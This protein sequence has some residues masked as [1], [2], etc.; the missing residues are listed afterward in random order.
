MLS[1]PQK[2][3]PNFFIA[4]ALPPIAIPNSKPMANIDEDFILLS[5]VKD[6]H[7]FSR[8]PAPTGYVPVETVGCGWSLCLF[9][10]SAFSVPDGRTPTTGVFCSVGFLF[11]VLL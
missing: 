2:S 11:S 9:F 7:G 5:I 1:V 6:G 3:S 10:P 4:R 8:C